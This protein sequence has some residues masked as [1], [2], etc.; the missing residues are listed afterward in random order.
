MRILAAVLAGIVGTVA[1][2]LALR[3]VKVEG[4]AQVSAGRYQIVNGTPDQARNIMLLDTATGQSWI[5]CIGEL[6]GGKTTATQWCKI[7][8]TDATSGPVKD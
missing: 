2:G 7:P 6:D 4:Q 8:R 5:S 3:P 1:L